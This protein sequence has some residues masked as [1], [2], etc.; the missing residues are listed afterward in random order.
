MYVRDVQ[1]LKE[2][3]FFFVSA[4]DLG[5]IFCSFFVFNTVTSIKRAVRLVREII[6]IGFFSAFPLVKSTDHRN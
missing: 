3:S 6:S 4:G 5:E 1:E 2:L